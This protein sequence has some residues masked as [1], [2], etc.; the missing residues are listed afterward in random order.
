MENTKGFEERIRELEKTRDWWRGACFVA[1]PAIVLVLG[2]NTFYQI[3]TSVREATDRVVDEEFRSQI[4]LVRANAMSANQL[5]EDAQERLEDANTEVSDFGR[6]LGR[7][8]CNVASQRGAGEEYVNDTDFPIEVAISSA[9]NNNVC[10]LNVR[11]D[12]EGLLYQRDNNES[13]S[14][15]CAGTFTVPV[16]A[17]Y[18]L[19]ERQRFRDDGTNTAVLIG[20]WQELRA[21]ACPEE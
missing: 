4:D 6:F 20:S 11:V 7:R 21:G 5:I 2:L 12:N 15:Q 3:P 8:W 19:E 1:I 18:F 17:T 16:G 9:S 13:R 10:L 14:K